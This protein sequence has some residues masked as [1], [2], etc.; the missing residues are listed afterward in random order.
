MCFG[1]YSF[2]FTSCSGLARG[3]QKT[4]RNRR[5]DV[6]EGGEWGVEKKEEGDRQIDGGHVG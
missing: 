6:A 4:E 1:V 5:Y 2:E 3:S